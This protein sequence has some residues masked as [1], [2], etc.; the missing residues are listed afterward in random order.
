M[1]TQKSRGGIRID[2]TVNSIENKVKDA[3]YELWEEQ[4]RMEEYKSKVRPLYTPYQC[5]ES[6]ELRGSA[7]GNPCEIWSVRTFRNHSVNSLK[8]ARKGSIQMKCPLCGNRPRKDGGELKVFVSRETAE[9]Y[10]RKKNLNPDWEWKKEDKDVHI[11]TI[12]M[13]EGV[14]E[15]DA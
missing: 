2:T 5:S 4:R 6:T 9:A 11:P 13:P 1:K 7:K 12:I 15:N 3:Q 10:A 14:E 8:E